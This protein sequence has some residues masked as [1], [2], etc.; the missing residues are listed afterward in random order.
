ME[1]RFILKRL[2]IVLL[3]VLT[4][5][6]T[7]FSVVAFRVN[8]EEPKSISTSNV[9][10]DLNGSMIDGKKFDVANYPYN[11]KG[12]TTLLSF[13][14]YYYSNSSVKLDDYGL[15]VYVY[16]PKNYTFV[17]GSTS[18]QIQL[19]FGDSTSQQFSKY[20]L[21]FVSKSNGDYEGLFYKFRVSLSEEQK[22]KA[23]SLLNS[24]NRVYRVSGFELLPVG[25]SNAVEFPVE[26]TYKFSG[27]NA[28][29]G[30][31]N[32]D[33]DTLTCVNQ[34][35]K[36]ITLDVH[37]T[38]YRP[39]GTNG[40]DK[41]TQDSLHSVYFS[42]PNDVLNE[43]GEMV[44]VHAR[45]LDAV[46]HPSLVIGDLDLFNAFS[47]C[48]GRSKECHIDS[49]YMLAGGY[50]PHNWNLLGASG[51]DMYYD[52]YHH[53]LD[54]PA[55][56][57]L[58]GFKEVSSTEKSRNL[59]YIN[60]LFYSGSSEDSA[61]DY[62]VDGN[63]LQAEMK[64]MTDYYK[65][66]TVLGKYSKSLFD[67]VAKEFTDKTIWADEKFSLSST[68]IK[69]NLW[70]KWFGSSTT[71]TF[72]DIQAIQKVTADDLQSSNE[73]ISTSLYVDVSDVNDFKTYFNSNRRSNT[74]Y[75]FRY[76]VSDYFSQEVSVLRNSSH[77]LKGDYVEEVTSNAYFFSQT[78]NLDFDI[79]DLT[80]SKG[81]VNTIIP[82]T[83]SPQDVIQDSTP[84]VYVEP[85]SPDLGID[86]DFS[87]FWDSIKSIG[88]MMGA[89]IVAVGALF[90]IVLCWPIISIFLRVLWAGIKL[91]LKGLIWLIT[92]P[93][94]V[95]GK[96]IKSA[97]KKKKER[98]K[99][100]VT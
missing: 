44:A 100:N 64:V 4:C 17:I 36:T 6:S 12:H 48:V 88:K 15:Y 90:L 89:I 29:Y 40:K 70:G 82:V 2:I 45:W 50:S 46:L 59:S 54:T 95:I 81:D 5:F 76:Q 65:D 20:T 97:S 35:L 39:E 96:M 49:E 31:D 25:S 61:D 22:S 98:S 33:K 66:Y 52:Y 43:Y 84:P 7:F 71:E 92:F 68:K 18:N 51:V 69:D 60:M 21:N 24:N 13:F 3:V 80:F 67:D 11:D 79:I 75:L 93:F 27:Y 86:L 19:A 53:E 32:P 99:K 74:T 55:P 26:N 28:G 8:A 87:S 23:M 30:P 58:K 14:E 56:Y 57:V 91:L 78:V 83:S 16:N 85:D 77:W 38:F 94:N 72:K 47:S 1:K 62:T 34:G 41:Y 37:S 10:D 9:L 63:L 73:S 42:V